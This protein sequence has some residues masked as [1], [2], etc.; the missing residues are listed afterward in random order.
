[1]RK[2][3]LP[4]IILTFIFQGTD[5]SPKPLA[6]C[7]K[8]EALRPMSAKFILKDLNTP[9]EL[10]PDYV[11]SVYELLYKKR[12]LTGDMQW[13]IDHIETG[14]YIAL[15]TAKRLDLTVEEREKI[16]IA[17]SFHDIGKLYN[18]KIW[19]SIFTSDRKIDLKNDLSARQ[20]I[21]SHSFYAIDALD[22]LGINLEDDIK[23]LIKYHHFPNCI[24][25][26]RLCF[27]CEIIAIADIADAATNNRPYSDNQRCRNFEEVLTTIESD[28]QQKFDEGYFL[29][30]EVYNAFLNFTSTFNAKMVFLNYKNGES[31]FMKPSS[32]EKAIVIEY[33]S[34]KLAKECMRRLSKQSKNTQ[35]IDSAA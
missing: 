23:T 29:H 22:E 34:L 5:L 25:D 28:W 35:A 13:L 31:F 1:M 8:P 30:R 32:I 18:K 3:I 10:D 7:F 6:A 26:A 16:S 17:F 14:R 9:K 24:K 2:L 12:G 4:I 19:T 15:S 20:E 33:N 27:L 21:D 11:K